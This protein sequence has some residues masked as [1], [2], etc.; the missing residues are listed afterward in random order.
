VRS[1]LKTLNMGMLAHKLQL[2][3]GIPIP[4]DKAMRQLRPIIAALVV[5]SPF[6][7]KADPI[8]DIDGDG[9]LLGAWGVEVMGELLD[10]AFV[11]G[12]CMELFSGCDEASDFFFEDGFVAAA[13]S[14][15]LI[16]QVFLDGA[17]GSFDTIPG[18]TAGCIATVRNCA[19]LSPFPTL[20]AGFLEGIVADNNILERFDSNNQFEDF[21]TY[22]TRDL[23][24]EVFAVWSRSATATVPG[25]DTLA[26]LG[27]GLA[28]LGLA[29]RR[30][31]A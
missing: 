11:D 12:S 26:L 15:S 8:L 17:F 5:L 22:D 23:D 14:Q 20:S 3:Q 21:A 24:G 2:I 27:I 19:V 25:P 9:Q 29:R 4:G 13:A 10:V 28:G 31:K 1:W 16:D 7:A 18:L 30:K 6:V